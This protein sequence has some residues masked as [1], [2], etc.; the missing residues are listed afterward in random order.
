MK[1][2]FLF[3]ALI[4]LAFSTFAFATNTFQE[5]VSIAPTAA[6]IVT[7]LTP[8]IVL[9][10]TWLVKVA[11][12]VIPGWAT[13]LVVTAISAAVTWAS[14]LLENPDLSW[15]QQFGFGLL[16]VFINQAYRQFTN[17]EK[18]K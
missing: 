2:K 1:L 11:K 3:T 13:M 15:L 17:T 14:T 4:L 12:P 9:G 7:W 8:F 18:P 10:A 6:T 5:E 16:A